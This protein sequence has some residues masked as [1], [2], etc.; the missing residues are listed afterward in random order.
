MEAGWILGAAVVLAGGC[1]G[2]ESSGPAWNPDA[3]GDGGSVGDGAEEEGDEDN[4]P[5]TS[6]D[7]GADSDGPGCTPGQVES[8]GCPDGLSLGEWTCL[9]DGSG[10]GPCECEGPA[11]DDGMVDDGGSTSGD[12]GVDEDLLC[13]PG[14]ANDYSTCVP[15][16]YFD[17]MPEGYVYPAPYNGN[18]NYR[19]PVALLD[20]DELDPA[21]QLAPNFRLDEIAQ[22]YKGRYAVVQ[23]HAIES[24]QGLR[25]QVGAIGVNSGYRSPAYNAGLDGAATYSRHMYGDAYDLDPIEVGL[26]TLEN[27]CTGSGGMLVEYTSHVH[28]DFR[29]DAVDETLFGPPMAADQSEPLMF[30]AITVEPDGA[31]MAPAEG[32]TEGEPVRRWVARAADGSVITEAVGAR[33][34]PPLGTVRVDVRIGAQ[35]EDSI[36]WTAP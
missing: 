13:F 24:L 12:G 2:H 17:P 16:H 31:L 34:D 14:A 23:P 19:A 29:F 32:F 33:F 18:D 11:T 9:P 4:I 7:G 36:E 8:C 1:G 15:Y 6:A 25:D 3:Q 5:M 30:G 26:S 10:F 22:R 20:L 21:L 27:A 28:C 35:V